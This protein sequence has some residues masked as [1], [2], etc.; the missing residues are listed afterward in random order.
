LKFYT[1]RSKNVYK[2][3]DNIVYGLHEIG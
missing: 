2:I 3:Y 1:Q